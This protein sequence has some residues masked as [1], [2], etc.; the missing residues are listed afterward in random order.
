[1]IKLVLNKKNQ[2]ILFTHSEKF[3]HIFKLIIL[4]PGTLKFNKNIKIFI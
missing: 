4:R 3:I 2:V 1:M